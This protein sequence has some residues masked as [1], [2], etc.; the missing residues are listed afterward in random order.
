MQNKDWIETGEDILKS[1]VNAVERQDFAGLSKNIENKVNDTIGRINE[2]IGQGGRVHYGQNNMRSST[3]R[4]GDPNHYAK[5][6]EIPT[7]SRGQ[8]VINPRQ[9]PQLYKKILPGT[10]SGPILKGIGIFGSVL[11]GISLFSVL[12]VAIFEGGADMWLA[13]GILGGFFMGNLG[14]VKLGN[15]LKERIARF[16]KYVSRVGQAQYC[17][18]EQLAVTVE[19][20]VSF[21]KKDVRKMIDKGFFLQ[22]H[23]DD[24]GTTLITSNEMYQK[25]IEAENS[26]KLREIE[27]AKQEQ[28]LLENKEAEGEYPPEVQKVLDEGYEY[29]RHIR[30]SND[31]IPGE[32]ISR[33]LA[34]LEDIMGRIFEQVKKN[35]DNVAD[36]QKMMKFYLPSTRKLIDTYRELDGQPSFGDNN[37]AN[38]KEEIENTLDIINEAFGKLFDDMFEDAAW[39]I[40]TEISTMKTMLAKEGL[41]GGKDF[42]LDNSIN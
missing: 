14:L 34:T 33:K 42:D 3:Y 1:V 23:I 16:K 21:V 38:T 15:N 22:G 29:I 11:I 36:V 8:V 24:M 19:K 32:E 40:S 5:A 28:L 10:F 18:L 12:M 26:R 6:S 4:T 2:K 41:T 13:S 37:V 27:T 31:A 17:S 25:Y 39:D 7:Q 9:V 20:K 30:E 35:P